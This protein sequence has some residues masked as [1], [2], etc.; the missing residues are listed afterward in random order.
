[1]VVFQRRSDPA[2]NPDD[3][4]S[5]TDWFSEAIAPPPDGLRG[6]PAALAKF[7]GHESGGQHVSKWKGGSI[8]EYPTVR[9]IAEWAQVDDEALVRLAMRDQERRAAAKK[10]KAR[11]FKAASPSRDGKKPP[12]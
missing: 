7:C 8:P 2:P 11:P 5:F 9:K 4:Q 12:R 10:R 1:M 3:Y 6:R